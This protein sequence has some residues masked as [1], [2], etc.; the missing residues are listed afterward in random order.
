[1]FTTELARVQIRS[2]SLLMYNAPRE[3]TIEKMQATRLLN[4]K[5]DKPIKS[6]QES[7]QKPKETPKESTPP[8]NP[9]S[10]YV[11]T[12]SARRIRTAMNL[13]IQMTPNTVL[14]NPV[15]NQ[16]V[17]HRLSVI[18]LTIPDQSSIEQSEAHKILL[19]PFL[20]WLSKTMHVKTYIWKCELQE[21]GV[22]H[23]HIIT[24][25]FIRI[26][27]VKDKWNTILEKASLMEDYKVKYNKFSPPSTQVKEVNHPE[28]MEWYMEKYVAKYDAEKGSVGGKVWDCSLDLRGKKL[29]SAPLDCTIEKSLLKQ[30]ETYESTVKEYDYC[31]IISFNKEVSKDVLVFPYTHLYIEYL[32]SIRNYKPP[33]KKVKRKSQFANLEGLIQS[34]ICF[35]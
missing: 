27:F 26:D 16:L 22:L 35:N 8:L 31:R 32:D 34:E 13:L 21:R 14:F 2:S 33:P 23:Y 6:D 10:G 7:T 30:L 5:K 28:E 29:F 25:S 20:D 4:L 11:T 17:N 19:R 15:T 12:H 9:Y 24:P 18:T 3:S 1:M